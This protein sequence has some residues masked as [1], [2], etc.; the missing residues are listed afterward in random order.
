MPLSVPEAGKHGTQK[1]A[2]QTMSELVKDV[3]FTLYLYG[4][5]TLEYSAFNSLRCYLAQVGQVL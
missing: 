2:E 5:P 3:Q 1:R 4:A